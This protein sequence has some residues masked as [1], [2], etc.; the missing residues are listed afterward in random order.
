MQSCIK[1]RT[2]CLRIQWDTH[3]LTMDQHTRCQSEC[4]YVVQWQ[5][6]PTKESGQRA[7]ALQWL[8]I[9]FVHF[10]IV[11]AV[12][13]AVWVIGWVRMTRGKIMFGVR[14]LIIIIAYGYYSFQLVMSSYVCFCLCVY[15]SSL[16]R[17]QRAKDCEELNLSF[18]GQQQR[19]E[20]PRW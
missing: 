11:C 5:K 19:F 15:K 4:L 9:H 8:T 10:I 6:I 12:P 2:I 16:I 13:F 14:N 7:C 3:T 20:C 18:A 17:W 1:Y